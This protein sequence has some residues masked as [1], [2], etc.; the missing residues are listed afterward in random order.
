M[1]GLRTA[2]RTLT[3]IPLWG[4]DD[5]DLSAALPWFPLVGL[6]LGL[7]L[8]LSSVLWSLLPVPPWHSG[9]AVL[10]VIIYVLL[11]RGFHLDGLADWADSMGGF[12]REKR[13]AIMKD[14]STGVFGAIA[15]MLDLASKG[16]CYERLLSS[17]TSLL[18]L[19][20]MA[21]SRAMM[22]ELITTLPYAR[23]GNGTARPFVEGARASDRIIAMTAAI[24]LCLAFGPIGFAIFIFAWIM[25]AIY[26]MYCLKKFG[27]ITG[28]LLGAANEMIEAALLILCALPGSIISSWNP[29]GF[30]SWI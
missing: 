27:G 16:V 5:G 15:I 19:P 9:L 14:P 10:L 18:I 28:D 2:V 4:M 24:G 25:T 13:L 20:V 17:R 30:L 3:S 1:K 6:F 29:W 21:V 22:V 8:F 23:T 12:D 26:R 7:I 11:T